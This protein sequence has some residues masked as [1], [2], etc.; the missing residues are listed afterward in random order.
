[1]TLGF[2]SKDIDSNFSFF[3]STHT[4]L[5]DVKQ[6][7]YSQT[8]TPHL[9]GWLFLSPCP[10]CL[11]ETF[12]LIGIPLKSI[13]LCENRSSV[14]QRRCR[15]GALMY[16]HRAAKFSVKHRQRSTTSSRN[17]CLQHWQKPSTFPCLFITEILFKIMSA[18]C[19]SAHSMAS[20]PPNHRYSSWFPSLTQE[21]SPSRHKDW[22]WL[23]QELCKQ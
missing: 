6:Y 17:L 22:L 4:L 10:G 13:R 20:R 23:W 11:S 12:C 14:C 21:P 18:R 15:I 7:Y 19:S 3:L 1:M 9:Q 16:K 5:H 8:G 2:A